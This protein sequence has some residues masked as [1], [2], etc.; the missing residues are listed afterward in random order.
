MRFALFFLFFALSISSFAQKVFF[1]SDIPLSE[2]HMTPFYA[3]VA[4]NEK[5]IF[6]GHNDYTIY[7]F[8]R[9]S[10]QKTWDVYTGLKSSSPPVL[11]NSNVLTGGNDQ[12][13]VIEAGRGE[14]VD[15]LLHQSISNYV[16]RNNVLYA[17]GLFEGGCV[18]AYDLR[19]NKVL[20]DRYIGHGVDVKPYFD[21]DKI[22]VNVDGGN[23]WASLSYDNGRSLT[24]LDTITTREDLDPS[25]LREFE[26]RTHD[27]KEVTSKKI[28]KLFKGNYGGIQ[29]LKSNGKVT[30]I[31]NADMLQ[32][33]VLGDKLKTL[34]LINTGE[35]SFGKDA[36]G[37]DA[38]IEITSLLKVGESEVWFLTGNSI[39]IIDFVK[40]E[41]V[42]Q[43]SLEEW[44]PYTV[45]VF[46]EEIWLIS[47]KDGQLYG[48]R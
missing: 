8:D 48:L 4:V 41:L 43:I 28:E 22:V 35:M 3:A 32:F 9:K 31:L 38:Y 40:M 26:F 20:W 27:G 18:F 19:S 39:T 1:K 45:T 11:T 17:T 6:F 12:T 33:L 29:D 21:K 2:K 34:A 23:T 46:N 14:V 30:V 10:N 37:E 24:G 7:A 47:S 42:R 44:L 25:C 13:L 15:T 5:S 16:V 36:Y